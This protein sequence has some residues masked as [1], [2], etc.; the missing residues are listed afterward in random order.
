VAVADTARIPLSREERTLIVEVLRWARANGWRK[1]GNFDSPWWS[2]KGVYRVF[3]GLFDDSPV[4]VR[5]DDKAAKRA[6]MD[7]WPRSVREG[8]DILVA[9]GVLPA[10][11]SSAHADGI[12]AGI[13]TAESLAEDVVEQSV[14]DQ[15]DLLLARMDDDEARRTLGDILDRHP[16]TG[17]LLDPMPFIRRAQLEAIVGAVGEMLGVGDA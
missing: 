3:F 5:V 14:A 16:Q 2:L 10:M 8:V 17:D 11:F 1:S 13:E 12:R 15:M 7:F 6:V 9:S 4:G